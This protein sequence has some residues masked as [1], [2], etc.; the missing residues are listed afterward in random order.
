[1]NQE[2]K[3]SIIEKMKVER[4]RLDKN[5]ALLSDEDMLKPGVS[6]P[7]G[8]YT[9]KD[10][11]AHLIEWEQMFLGWYEAGLKGEV[12]VVPAPGIS[13][14]NLAELN[15]QIYDKHKDRSLD[16]IKKE[17]S[18]S[19]HQVFDI[20]EEMPVD[21]FFEKGKYK[22]MNLKENV[23]GYVKANTGNHYRWAK[24]KIRKWL[25]SENRL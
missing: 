20:I 25:K 21:N 5:L 19:F 22:W 3:E 12:P 18:S 2:R 6:G 15:K 10:I 1:M 7:Q 17:F 9:I 24:T 23:G 8:E 11:L 4:R 14:R 13:W 16:E